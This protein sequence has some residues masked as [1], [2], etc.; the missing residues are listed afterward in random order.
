MGLPW[1]FP[2]WGLHWRG[3]GVPQKVRVLENAFSLNIFLSPVPLLLKKS[4]AINRQFA[5]LDYVG[6][7]EGGKGT[8]L[9]LGEGAGGTGGGEQRTDGETARRPGS[10]SVSRFDSLLPMTSQHSLETHPHR[11]SVSLS[12]C[13]AA[14]GRSVFVSVLQCHILPFSSFNFLIEKCI[15]DAFFFVDFF[16]LCDQF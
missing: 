7:V 1:R 11:F 5:H 10:G 14:I 9:V 13:F 12:H 3:L 16:F 6:R 8:G 4:L 2:R 15:K